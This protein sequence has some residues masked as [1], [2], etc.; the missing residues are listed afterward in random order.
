MVPLLKSQ[1]HFYFINSLIHWHLEASWKFD[2][3]NATFM[4]FWSENYISNHEI[5]A[6]KTKQKNHHHNKTPSAHNMLLFRLTILQIKGDWRKSFACLQYLNWG[7]NK[8]GDR[9][10][11]RV[12]CDKTRGNCFKLKE[13]RLRLDIREKV[14]VIRWWDTGTGYKRC[15]GW[16]ITGDTQGQS[17]PGF[18]QPI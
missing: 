4:Q 5:A 18:E 6:D 9:H 17:G 12:C 2:S 15:G 13:G 11:S 8:E 7:Y 3:I 14:F 10:F 16:L 1:D